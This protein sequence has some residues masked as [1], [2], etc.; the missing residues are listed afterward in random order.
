MNWEEREKGCESEEES[1]REKEGRKEG[2]RESEDG[3]TRG[4]GTQ[5]GL[6]LSPNEKPIGVA[7]HG[8]T[9]G[10]AS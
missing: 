9:A 10:T 5:T 7:Q 4:S 8:G 1:R 6:T 2:E 3:E